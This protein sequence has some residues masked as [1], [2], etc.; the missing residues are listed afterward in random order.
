[1]EPDEVEVWVAAVA[2]TPFGCPEC[3]APRVGMHVRPCLEDVDGDGRLDVFFANYGANGLFLQRQPD[4]FADASAAWGIAMDARWDA[5]AFADWDHDGALDLY[6]NGTVTGGRSYPDVLYRQSAGRLV[7]VTPPSLGLLHA[8]HGVAWADVDADGDLDLALTGV[9]PDGM[10][11]V[12]RNDLPD[13]LRPR[14]VQVR[15]L[16]PRGLATRSGA[17]VRVY[18]AG[19]HRLLGMRVV[20]AGSGYNAQHDLPVHVGVGVAARVDVEVTVPRGGHRLVAWRR[21]VE[22]AALGRRPLEVRRQGVPGSA[23]RGVTARPCAPPRPS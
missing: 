12:M 13:S 11:Q 16:D 20:D 2:E 7:D 19:T 23:A 4:R 17:E 9:R 8:D 21:G 1:M 15:V 22:V 3:V 18:A 6:V 14:S 10:H 5:C